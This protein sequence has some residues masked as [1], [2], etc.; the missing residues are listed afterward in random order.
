[1]FGAKLHRSAF[2]R[3]AQ[4]LDS[5]SEKEEEREE[6]AGQGSSTISLIYTLC[7]CLTEE[8]LGLIA[9]PLCGVCFVFCLVAGTDG[10]MHL[11][12]PLSTASSTP[13]S[14]SPPPPPPPP[15][16]PSVGSHA[17]GLHL[18][19]ALKS[20]FH[21]DYIR[22]G[23]AAVAAAAHHQA[24]AL[25]AQAAQA[26]QAVQHDYNQAM[27]ASS[28]HNSHHQMSYHSMFTPSRDPG[29]MWRCRSCGKEVT[30][31]WH[32]FHSH[33]AQRSLCPYCPATYSR[34]DT[35]RSHLRVKHPERLI[36]LNTSI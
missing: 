21:L 1:M 22:N 17:F 36:K 7:L 13:R 4:R 18:S 24:A 12:T 31:R 14:T 10:R 9:A 5:W 26:V 16:A 32:H 34:I 20:E 2:L 8:S 11:G 6:G 23:N 35:L 28:R 19:N 29:T 30:N 15:M 25:A 27:N 3:S 33:T